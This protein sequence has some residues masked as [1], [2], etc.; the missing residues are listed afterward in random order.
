VTRAIPARHTL[1]GMAT[2]ARV[3]SQSSPTPPPDLPARVRSTAERVAALVCAVNALVLVAL[4]GFYVYEIATGQATQLGPAIMSAAL[5]ALF[6]V[7]LFV[8]ARTWWR[9]SHA[10]RTLSLVW[11][12]LLLPVAYSAL[13]SGQV[14]IGALIGLGAAVGLWAAVTAEPWGPG[15]AP[16]SS[17]RG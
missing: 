14:V 7:G 15:A 3:G 13:S 8:L 4:A 17:P 9:G 6:A 1:V 11:F 12:A 5:I 16:P 2:N 10:G